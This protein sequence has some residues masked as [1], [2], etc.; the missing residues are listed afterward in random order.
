MNSLKTFERL[1]QIRS[2]NLVENYQRIFFH[3]LERKNFDNNWNETIK[4][5]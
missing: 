3:D 1:L 2:R 4:I 5:Y